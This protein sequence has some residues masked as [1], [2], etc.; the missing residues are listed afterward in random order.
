MESDQP[1][2]SNCLN[3]FLGKIKP[4]IKADTLTGFLGKVTPDVNIDAPGG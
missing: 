1:A 4:D 2:A 3:A